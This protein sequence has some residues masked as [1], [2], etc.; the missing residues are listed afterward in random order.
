MKL[1]DIPM[2]RRA[3][4]ASTA[5]AAATALALT[6]CSGSDSSGSGS[7]LTIF[8][9]ATGTIT[10]NFSPFSATA[11]QPTRGLIFEPLFWYNLATG[12]DPEPQLG[13]TFSW[14]EDGTQLTITVREGVTWSDGEPFTAADVAFTFN[15]IEKTPALNTSG[16]SATAEATDD[17]TVVLTFPEPSFTQEPDV[18]GGQGIVPE[19]LWK[20]VDDPTTFTNEAPVGTGPFT[21]DKMSSQSYSLKAN[22]TYWD[23]EPA[24]KEV[25]Y[26]SLE[27]ADAA[28]ASLTAG[29]VDWMSAYLPSI[30]TIVGSK[31]ELS[32]INTPT[33]TT[34]LMTASNA[35]L[36]CTGPQTDPAVRRAMYYAMDRAQLN[37]LAGGGFAGVASPTLL[38]AERDSDW[39][40][41][42][43][44]REV[45]QTADTDKANQILDEAGWT[46]GSDGVRVKD[47]ERLSMTVITVTGWSDYISLNDTLV[48]QFAKV[49][50]ELKPSQVS[51][52]E[53]NQAELTGNYQL[54]LDSIGLGSSTNPY[55]TYNPKLNSANTVPV[56]ESTSAGNVGRYSNADVDAAIRAAAI[57]NDVEAQK[58]A[59][60]TIQDRLV[61]GIP[62]IPIYVNSL[63][64]EFNNSRF[65]GWPSEEDLYALPASWKAWDCGIILRK[66]KPVE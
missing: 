25:R 36:G 7:V 41:N 47:G 54:A 13:Q 37:K 8:N 16:L 31:K 58:Q 45:P 20:D 61:E 28:S 59:Y 27:S 34:C 30:D 56:G 60:A 15:L 17:T 22:P 18:L 23:G 4:L 12:A 6:A 52:N 43:D 10:T 53:W 33:M 38:L 32:Y 62:Y 48:Q 64:T 26:I 21:L 39:I 46:M 51:W 1:L 40:A 44:N 57:T 65:T 9:G 19:H 35:E 11:L 24:V 3:F 29:E 49:G 50:I 5:T 63:L 14:N 55:F 2:R 42:A 66:V